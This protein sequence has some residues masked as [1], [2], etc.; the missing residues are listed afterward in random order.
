M[1]L[2]KI[3]GRLRIALRGW[4]VAAA[5][6]WLGIMFAPEGMLASWG[7]RIL[8]LIY[9]LGS[10][11]LSYLMKTYWP[12]RKVSAGKKWIAVGMILLALVRCIWR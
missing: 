1:N 11:V 8:F 7:F 4:A 2:E 3:R 10:G 12:E 6:F 9:L 5:A